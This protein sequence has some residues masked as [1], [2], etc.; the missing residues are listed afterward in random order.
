MKTKFKKKGTLDLILENDWDL[1]WLKNW[2]DNRRAA[3]YDITK[4]HIRDGV[5]CKLTLSE[6]DEN[7]T[8]YIN[9][10]KKELLNEKLLKHFTIID[11]QKAKDF[12]DKHGYLNVSKVNYNNE[13]DIPDF[14]PFLLIS[15]IEIN[16]GSVML[17][18]IPT[19]DYIL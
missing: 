13:V 5:D 12:I 11:I 7:P 6:D 8:K 17:K 9:D 3:T 14:S 18:Y 2:Q 15:S 4:L 1:K 16:Q 19:L 10:T